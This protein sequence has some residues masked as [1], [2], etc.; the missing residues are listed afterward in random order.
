MA[1]SLLTLPCYF[2]DKPRVLLVLDG[3]A[4]STGDG[5]A[6]TLSSVRP[7]F[8]GKLAQSLRVGLF[9]PRHSVTKEVHTESVI[10]SLAGIVLKPWPGKAWLEA[11][12]M[13]DPEQ[14]VYASIV[15][16]FDRQDSRLV[17]TSDAIRR[18]NR[19]QLPAG[20]VLQRRHERSRCSW[21]VATTDLTQRDQI[22]S[23]LKEMNLIVTEIHDGEGI[24]IAGDVFDSTVPPVISTRLR[25]SLLAHASGALLGACKVGGIHGLNRPG[26]PLDMNLHISLFSE[27]RQILS[28]GRHQN[29][30]LY[31]KAMDWAS[32]AA[33]GKLKADWLFFVDK[34]L[35]S[36]LY[37]QRTNMHLTV[38]SDHRTDIGSDCAEESPSIFATSNGIGDDCL[39][40]ET[41]I[42]NKWKNAPLTLEE[43]SWLIFPA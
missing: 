22:A 12:E 37:E 15:R 21:L 25:S 2:M 6:T 17:L 34:E 41:D 42:E 27:I 3:V 13:L 31:I 9:D 20:I 30:I 8:L 28:E 5:R 43:L 40:I 4:E 29:F 23:T 7:L 24:M 19:V 35:I 33:Q 14:I 26:S 38:I 16:S 10:T 1:A 32:H 18:L 39:F 36:F 11:A